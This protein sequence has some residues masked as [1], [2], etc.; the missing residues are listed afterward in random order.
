MK[1][2]TIIWI[3]ISGLIVSCTATTHK[4][5]NVLLIVADDLGWTDAGFM[6]STYYE[7]PNLDQLASEG[8]VFT[9]AYAGAANCA[10]S[11][12]CLLSGQNTPRHGIY[13]VS[14]SDR[15][16]AQT[17]KI[18][19]VSNTESLPDNCITLA[20]ELKNYGYTTGTIGKYHVGANPIVHG[21]DF[22]FAGSH[23]GHPK[24][25]WAPY[26]IPDVDAPE[27][28]YLTDRL[29]SEAIGFIERNKNNAFFLYLPYYTVHTPIEA[30]PHLAAKYAKKKGTAL[31]N[32][33]EYA[34][35][36]ENMDS[37]IGSI[38]Q[39]IDKNHL[40]QNTLVIFT[41]DNGGVYSISNQHPLRGGKGSY[42]E[43][44]IRVPMIVRYPGKVAPQQTSNVPVVNLDLYPTILDIIG[45]TPQKPTL[46]GISLKQLWFE[47]ETPPT[48]PLYWHFP[49]YLEAKKTDSLPWRDPL[50]RTRPGSVI[51]YG[52]W[53]LHEYFEDEDIELYNLADDL[54]E[55]TNLAD[56]LPAKARELLILLHEWQN[57]THADMPQGANP[58]YNEVFEKQQIDKR[59][60]P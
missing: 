51:S 32:N 10:P 56:S 25:Y 46:D 17:R 21:F 8:M 31:H 29:T 54:G 45:A 6:G 60:N 49:I 18:I 38:L 41:S 20:S 36:I 7:T 47:N 30:K 50:F 39:Y 57:A 59:L 34:A 42:Y 3:L 53:K 58:E 2:K 1:K 35:M 27:G 22:N 48:R 23:W 28:E 9:R 24:T 19:P 11:R 15:G 43:G 12:A 33:P 16:K 52:D 44:G 14:P 13:T 55:N 40:K 26:I 37:C 5:P 4:K